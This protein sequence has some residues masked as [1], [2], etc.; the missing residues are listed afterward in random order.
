MLRSIST[1]ASA[2][3]KIAS[4]FFPRGCDASRLAA[5]LGRT[6]TFVAVLGVSFF[7]LSSEEDAWN[8]QDQQSV[9]HAASGVLGDINDDSTTNLLDA[10]Y[11]LNWGF[12]GGPPPPCSVGD[13]DGNGV[14]FILIDT[15]Y[16]LD[17]LFTGGPAPVNC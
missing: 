2:L 12:T 17:Y 3:P 6:V 13:C 4:T 9:A 5:H 11:M 15:L 8:S 16:L 14:V 7:L 1:W 10:V